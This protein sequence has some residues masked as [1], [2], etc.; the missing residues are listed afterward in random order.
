MGV[1]YRVR[2][3]QGELRALKLLK[4]A[5]ARQRRRFQ[6]EIDALRRLK[7]PG[8]VPIRDAGEHG[9]QPYLVMDLIEGTSLQQRIDRGGPLPIPAAVDLIVELA[10]ALEHAH[11]QGVLHRDLKPDNVLLTPGGQALLTD[12][13]LARE[14]DGAQTQLTR[15]GAF[16]GT[17]GYWP[18]EQARGDRQAVDARSDVYALGAT[19]YAA[20]TGEAPGA[21]D[22][23]EA[24]RGERDVAPPSR[25]RPD[26]D[27]G[28]EAMCLR[29]LR[30]DPQDRYPSAR[31][32]RE[33]LVAQRDG[34][35][36]PTRR[37]GWV[38]ALVLGLFGAAG[39]AG[40]R[41]R[42]AEA[43]SAPPQVAVST[44]AL[45]A[46]LEAAWAVEE[47]D[48]ETVER[49]A[50][51]VLEADP[52]CARAYYLRGE[53]YLQQERAEAALVDLEQA[54][55]L[56]EPDAL[57]ARAFAHQSAGDFASAVT[58]FERAVERSPLD[59][60]LHQFLGD[61]R[62]EQ[63]DLEG[64]LV[65]MQRSLELAPDESY[66]AFALGVIQHALGNLPEAE[67][68]LDRA[69]TLYP[70][71]FE[72]LET[73]GR[74]RAK[75][76]NLLGAIADYSVLLEETTSRADLWGHRGTF[77][78]TLRDY[79]EALADFEEAVALAPEDPQ[80]LYLRGLSRQRLGD[81]R[82]ALA[83]FEAALAVRPD[84]PSYLSERGT[85]RAITGDLPGAIQ[86]F[87]RFLELAPRDHPQW[88]QVATDVLEARQALEDGTEVQL[89]DD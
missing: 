72:A 55:T 21:T 41:A 78:Y 9:A 88:E 75:R 27:A 63:G 31:A 61:A 1:V 45:L 5:G 7:H 87:E 71:D 59:F 19:L 79:P 3:P 54:V 43:P 64:A 18:P 6:R 22:L 85:Q 28:L 11:E 23:L 4:G 10:G 36:L 20:L 25:L 86:D 76:G 77:H 67:A 34:R 57:L 51:R 26:L 62:R 42:A 30:A 73:R 2:D 32:V 16:L 48:H 84:H 13:G 82:G 81:A 80:L 46:R 40:W 8:I 17:P 53:V 47:T 60:S 33:A 38:W 24:L 44:E 56:G 58:D 52:E 68:A 69:L 50:T 65:A 14:I 74:V 70:E 83:D 89:A 37:R 39:V 49:L 35:A 12:F 66:T 29:C 15:T